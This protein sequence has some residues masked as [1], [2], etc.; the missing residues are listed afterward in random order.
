VEFSPTADPPVCKITGLRQI[1]YQA[2]KK[3]HERRKSSRG[4][5]VERSQVSARHRGTRLSGSQEPDSAV[6]RRRPQS[7]RDD[8]PSRREMAHQEV[9]RAKNEPLALEIGDQGQIE[10]MPRMEG[11]VLVALLAPKKGVSVASLR[12]RAHP[13]PS[14]R[15]S[16]QT[17]SAQLAAPQLATKF[18]L[19]RSAFAR[20]AHRNTGEKSSNAKERIE[21]ERKL[22]THRGARKRFKSPQ[23]QKSSAAIPASAT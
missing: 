7:A 8:F 12:V 21:T 14:S 20:I 22:K 5:A 1:S 11:N 2:N 23:R 10:T 13:A 3:S 16:F 15:S 17:C 18:E 19:T 4:L 9:G 6:S